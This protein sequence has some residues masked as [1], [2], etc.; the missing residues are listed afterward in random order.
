M[1]QDTLTCG[2]LMKRLNEML[3]KNANNDLM[4]Q[5]ITFSQ[6]KMLVALYKSPD[7][8]AT[9]KEL[10]R[11][12]D[13]AQATTAGIAVRLEKKKLVEGYVD[14][15]DKR[16]KHIRLSEAGRELCER[17]KESM[18]RSE[19]WLMKALDEQEEAELH[20]LLQKIYDNAK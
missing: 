7:R 19:R 11:I 3:E 17:T 20:R 14:P 5:G 4:A 8:S 13:V 18:D 6:M 1:I 9:L 12:F 10:E 16:I 15:D 2:E